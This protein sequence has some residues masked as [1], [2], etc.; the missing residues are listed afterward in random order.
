M[1]NQLKKEAKQ[2]LTTNPDAQDALAPDQGW[3]GKKEKEKERERERER[4]REKEKS[5]LHLSLFI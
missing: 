3:G 1:S 5:W 2:V 4:E